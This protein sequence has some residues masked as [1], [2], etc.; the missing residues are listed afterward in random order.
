MS[1]NKPFVP[2]QFEKLTPEEME[3]RAISFFE[4]MDKRRTVR[5]F[6]SEP[7]P[8]SVIENA[9]RTASTA[10]SGAH[11]QPWFFAVVQDPETKHRIREA[12]EKEERENYSRRFPK[13]WLEDLE[14][15]GTNAVKTHIDIAPTLIIVFKQNYEIV[16]GARKKNYYVN[17]SV[18]IATGMLITALHNAGLCTLTHTPNPM[19]F[20][21]EILQRPKN[22]IP[23]ILLPVGY[24]KPGTK[25][26]DL[27]RKPLEAISAFY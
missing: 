5:E 13:E 6:S 10:P 19:A 27:T 7:V 9:I 18:G 20:L 14:Q 17:E 21:N 2:H 4:H 16:N 26:P 22:E 24:P 15:F 8:R 25:I 1:D 11:K 12:A 3:K 23:I